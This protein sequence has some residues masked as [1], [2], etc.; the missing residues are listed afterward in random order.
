M[1]D[2]ARS[3]FEIYSDALNRLE[4]EPGPLTPEKAEL[5]RFLRTLIGDYE[6]MHRLI[7]PPGH[8]ANKRP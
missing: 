6:P 2:P 5:M 4:A 8:R 7:S 1:T 3:P